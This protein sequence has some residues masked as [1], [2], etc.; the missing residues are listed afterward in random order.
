MQNFRKTT[1]FEFLNNRSV[2]VRNLKIIIY[3]SS[4]CGSRSILVTSINSNINARTVKGM[5]TVATKYSQ[6]GSGG[7]CPNG[8]IQ[9]PRLSP[10]RKW[11]VLHAT[12][13]IQ[14]NNMT[15]LCTLVFDRW[16]NWQITAGQRLTTSIS[17]ELCKTGL[18]FNDSAACKTHSKQQNKL[19]TK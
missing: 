16:K 1:P 3:K 18:F 11:C 19:S 2:S 14:H 12:A 4:N 13:N 17:V 6:F 15:A 7:V 8:A 9:I 10:S 5:A